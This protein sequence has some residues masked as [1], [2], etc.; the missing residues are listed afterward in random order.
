M[1]FGFGISDIITLST[2][3]KRAVDKYRNAPAEYQALKAEVSKLYTALSDISGVLEHLNG[4]HTVYMGESLENCEKLLKEIEKFLDKHE[5]MKKTSKTAVQERVKWMMSEQDEFVK[6]VKMHNKD[7]HNAWT[8]LTGV[9]TAEMY[10]GWQLSRSSQQVPAAQSTYLSIEVRRIPDGGHQLPTKPQQQPPPKKAPDADDLPRRSTEPMPTKNQYPKPSADSSPPSPNS[11]DPQQ[12]KFGNSRADTQ[13][14]L[15]DDLPS[16][17]LIHSP[18]PDG[19]ITIS[20]PLAPATSSS[21]YS[22]ASSTSSGQRKLSS[23]AST[24]SS[25][26][27]SSL[28]KSFAQDFGQSASLG[29]GFSSA[30]DNRPPPPEKDRKRRPSKAS[31]TSQPPAKKEQR[32]SWKESINLSK[33]LG[34]SSKAWGEF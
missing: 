17:P 15:V 2:L 10:H 8:R 20:P 18:T 11:A 34:S 1:S 7:L 12:S 25:S 29:T 6:K 28:F 9:W 5:A 14:T 24:K 3:A 13:V 23:A 21:A 32:K 16:Q 31:S 26:S 4:G 19:N 30:A 22:T 27:R 33:S